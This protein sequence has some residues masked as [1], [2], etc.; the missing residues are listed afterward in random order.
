MQAKETTYAKILCYKK[1]H[2]TFEKLKEVSVAEMQ[3]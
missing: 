2:H 3:R 1:E